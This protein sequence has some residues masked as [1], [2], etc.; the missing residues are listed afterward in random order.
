MM[1]LLPAVLVLLGRRVFWPLVPALRQHAQGPPV[2]VRRDGQLGRTAAAHRAGRRGRAAR[3]ARARHAQPARRLKQEDSFTSTARRRRRHGDAREGL[4][5]AGHPAHHRHHPGR[6]RRRHPRRGP[7]HRGRRQR[8]QGPY[9]RRAGPRS[10]SSPTAP[11]Q[12]AGETATIKALRAGLDGSYVGGPS[13]QQLDLKDT[14]APRPDDRRAARPRLRAAD[15]DRP[16]AGRS[17]R[18][19]SWWPP[20]SP[21]G[22]RPSASAGW[23]SGR[24]SASRAPT[25]D[26]GCCPSCS[27]S[28][29][30]STTASS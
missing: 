25:P 6:P 21:C 11:P 16:A 7:R 20:W 30:A 3:R 19:C 12:S 2:A 27:W 28:P 10:P 24:C 18:R 4:P 9:R 26:S 22:A 15:P 23:S 5:G 29:S 13:A 14:N 1:T 8:A 17:S